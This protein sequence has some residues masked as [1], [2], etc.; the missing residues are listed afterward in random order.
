MVVGE[1]SGPTRKL[2]Q[3]SRREFQSLKDQMVLESKGKEDIKNN[4]KVPTLGTGGWKCHPLKLKYTKW[5]R[6]K[7]EIS[8][9]F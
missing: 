9:S 2:L 8:R 5:S 6:F 3:K 1:Q 4:S 7:R